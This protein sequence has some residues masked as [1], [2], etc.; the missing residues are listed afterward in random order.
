M[1][2]HNVAAVLDRL[3][4]PDRWRPHV[5]T[6]KSPWVV[7][8]LRARG[9]RRFK[10]ATTLELAML[11]DAG[12]SDVLFAVCA[13]GA[14]ARAVREHATREP[15][16]VSVLVEGEDDLVDWVG[17]PVGVFVDVDTG[18]G[19]SGLP[20][21]QAEAIV[22]VARAVA[23]SGLRFAGLHAY[24]GAGGSRAQVERGLDQLTGVVRELERANCPPPEV[25]TS[26]SH[27]AGWATEHAALAAAVP[28][29]TVSPGTV[30]FHDIRTELRSPW[31]L[32]L[33][34]AA[35]VLTRVVSSAR[36]D[37]VT[38]DAGHKAIAA[39]TGDPTA[40]VMGHPGLAALTPWEEHLP[41]SV[42]PGTPRPERGDLLALVP[43]H[44]CPTVN[45]HDA[46]ILIRQGVQREVVAVAA[47]GHQ[48]PAAR[49][50][51]GTAGER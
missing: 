30:V 8:L 33:R 3:P 21:E 1:V 43:M 47:R 17:A 42:A 9:V 12:V 2:E 34:P 18:L 28:L 38:C 29:H 49:Q 22:A 5:K 32:G 7:D 50:Q 4:A 37:R 26:G 51:R 39:D 45:L 11:I 40:L 16:R 44:V 24:E 20:V 10:C 41:L 31:R 14:N 13:R 36:P 48:R 25:V 35:A 46:A 19:R 15:T 6:F 23:A 27:T